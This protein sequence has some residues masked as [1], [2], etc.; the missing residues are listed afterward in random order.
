MDNLRPQDLLPKRTQVLL[1]KFLPINRVSLLQFITLVSLR[2]L[3][4][5]IPILIISQ[6]AQQTKKC[7]FLTLAANFLLSLPF[8]LST[9]IATRAFS[10]LTQ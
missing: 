3:L 9:T 4:K 1:L 8:K 5:L 7:N 6:Q 10:H 2:S